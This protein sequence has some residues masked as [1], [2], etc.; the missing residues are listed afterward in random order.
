MAGSG[1][2]PGR[3]AFARP[4]HGWVVVA[5]A[6]V[7]MAIGFGV[8]YSFAA[9]FP[10]LQAEFQANRGDV[11]LIFSL[12]G[13]L[14][15][16]LGAL[17][18]PLAD[19]FGPGRVIA[20]GMVLVGIGLLAASRAE[21]LGQIYL[22]YSLAVGIGVGFAYVPAVG[23]VQ[24]WFVAR[25][26]FASGVAVAGIG[27]GTLAMP[28]LAAWLIALD[29]WRGGY[30]WL[31]LL[32]I[33]V[34]GGSA[35]L[36][37]HPPDGAT[38]PKE[39]A[40]RSTGMTLGAALRS[41]P[42]WLIFIAAGTTSFGMFIPFVHVAAYSVDHG[43]SATTGVL[44]V[45]LIGVGSILGRFVLGGIADRVGRRRAFA[46]MFVGMAVMELVWLASTGIV[47]LA[48]F[49]I[50]FGAFYGG[51]V[52][53]APALLA[54]YFGAR[55]ISSILGLAYSS[56][57]VGTLVGPTLAGYAFELAGTYTLPIGAAIALN[58]V[59]LG[60]LAK[61]PDPARWRGPADRS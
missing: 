16:S 49:A 52:A 1:G 12:S 26:G 36:I 43:H 61:L 40:A 32:S 54:D 27:V 60:A 23:A 17:S 47:P 48:A 6:H 15:F 30:L 51:F 22:T 37:E 11:A 41:A 13:F 29:G 10:A 38:V 20:G 57:A 19:R 25:R 3:R 50:L 53:L 7:V 46:A 59:A 21:T 35:L 45:S 44:L 9:F 34:G 14:Y 8:A 55:H 39:T 18:G 31:G 56:V 5:A 28:P 42:F 2:A 33:V 4:F 24:R 58:L